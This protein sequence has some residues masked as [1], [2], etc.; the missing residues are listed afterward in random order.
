[1]MWTAITTLAQTQAG[2]PGAGPKPSEEVTKLSGLWERLAAGDFSQGTWIELWKVVGQPLLLALVLVIAV[3][4]LSGWARRLTTSAMRRAH[5][6]ETLARFFGNVAKWMVMLL[7]GLA[8]LGT[9]DVETTS[10]AAVIAAMGFAIGMAFSGT[11]GNFAAGI[12]LLIFRPFK[13]GDV[14]RAAGV[15]GVI[16]EIGMFTTTF[17]TFQKSRVIVPN[18]KIFGDIIENVTHHP[19]RRQDVNVGTA[20]DADIDKVRGILE[21]VV[22]SVEGATQDPAPQVFLDGLGDNSINWQLRVWA[23]AATL[24]PMRENLIRD[25][26]KAL[27]AAGVGIPFPQRDVH[28]DGP[29]EIKMRNNN[30]D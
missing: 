26:K 18:G 30:A 19:V 4:F 8:I 9:F 28:F 27:N 11:L 20:Y 21:G 12:M 14:V 5:V 16:D 15:F 25:T 10:F 17:D 3:L 2:T 23:P 22:K 24:W 6:E 29:I 13:I 7:G 1:M